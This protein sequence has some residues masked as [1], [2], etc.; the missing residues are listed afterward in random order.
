[1]WCSSSRTSVARI[2][3]LVAGAAIAALATGCMS[4]PSEGDLPWAKQE[5]WEG[6][7]ALPSGML[8]Q[9]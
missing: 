4:D 5:L 8:Q 1:M 6:S 9:K 2:L 3:A 7:P